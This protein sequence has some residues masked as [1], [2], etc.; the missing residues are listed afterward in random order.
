M[1][2]PYF[3]LRYSR[4]VRRIS[5]AWSRMLRRLRY[6][7][8]P[9]E[10]WGH[11]WCVL[12]FRINRSRDELHVLAPVKGHEFDWDTLRDHVRGRPWPAYAHEPGKRVG[13]MGW[14]G[15]HLF[16]EMEGYS[17]QRVMM[18]KLV[19]GEFGGG[20]SCSLMLAEVRPTELQIET[21]ESGG[22]G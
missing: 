5:G 6:G 9:A 1:D 7:P 4:P 16:V 11:C 17:P 22:I 21:P 13:F 10:G 2:S 14:A 20:T 8:V 3:R 19:P 12:V 18:S 15:H